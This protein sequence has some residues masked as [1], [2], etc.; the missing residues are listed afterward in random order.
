MRSSRRALLPS[1]VESRGLAHGRRLDARV[2]GKGGPGLLDL[3]DLRKGGHVQHPDVEIGQELAQFA[4]FP[5][6]A[7]GQDNGLLG[8]VHGVLAVAG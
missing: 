5:L 7:G 6:V 2:L 8:V 3:A 4:D 1:S